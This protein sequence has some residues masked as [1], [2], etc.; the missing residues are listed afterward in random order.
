MYKTL[1]LTGATGG[2]G[3]KTAEKFSA[4]GYALA[5]IYK[6]SDAQADRLRSLYGCPVIKADI[7]R[8]DEAERAVNTAIK[9]LGHID[10]LINNAGVALPPKLI[11]EISEEEFDWIFD[12]NVKGAFNCI[13]SVLPHMIQ[14]KRG[15]IINISSIWGISGA[16]CETVYSA[17][18]SALIGLTR[19]LSK[20]TA[21]SG[22]RVNCVAPGAI[23]TAM[24]THLS[25]KDRDDLRM[26]TPLERLGTGED[27][28]DACCFLASDEADF[29]T[30]Q[31]LTVDGG[32][33]T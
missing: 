18:K 9:E 21:P 3:I 26:R 11:T 24:N 30:G 10:V 27:I 25:D 12:T 33:I 29:I 13:K 15:A 8:A 1:L 17:S 5:L 14:R 28:A 7:S 16:S 6:S 19:A 2:I 31:T 23:D 32:F 4:K 22:I 20:E